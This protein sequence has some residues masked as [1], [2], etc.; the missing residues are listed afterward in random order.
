MLYVLLHGS[1]SLCLDFFTIFFS[2]RDDL[3]KEWV[4]V[5]L[6]CEML[7]REKSTSQCF[8]TEAT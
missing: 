6:L 3:A 2:L 4:N 1:S 8:G 7:G 5:C